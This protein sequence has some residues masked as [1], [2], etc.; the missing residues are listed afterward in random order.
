M[1]LSFPTTLARWLTR[2]RL[3]AQGWVLLACLWLGAIVDFSTPAV[4]DRAGNVKFQDFVQFYVGGTL[5]GSG[6]IALLY[7]WHTALERM[8]QIAPQWR[9]GLP[10]VYG[11]QVV[12]L[13]IP[14]SRLSFLTAAGIWVA[15]SAGV[16][17][18]CC[19]ALCRACP[20]LSGQSSLFWL[21]A[22]AYP[23]CFHF[24]IRGQISALILCCFT[25]A[26]F[27]FRE[28]RSFLAGLALGTLAF[29]PQFLIALPV[30]FLLARAWKP[31][32]GVIAGVIGQLGLTW[33]WCGSSVMRQYAQTLANL[34]RLVAAT[35]TTEAHAQMHSLRSFFSL[36]LPWPQ[37]AIGLSII[38]SAAVIVLAVRVWRSDA[39]L[40]VRFSALEVAAVLVNPHL[41][42]YD[43]LALAPMLILL[44]DWVLAEAAR[45]EAAPRD[46]LICGL[47]GTYLLPLFGPLTMITHLQL[48]VVALV[49]LQ[50]ELWRGWSTQSQ[51]PSHI[52]QAQAR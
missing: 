39:P 11:P 3:L 15:I 34:P 14:F 51:R 28:G 27:A 32:A 38:S 50:W 1:A 43:L 44:A 21:L 2:R 25:L 16:Y 52:E 5:A 26:Y 36:L 7:D 9:F 49:W 31:L 8:H 22:L 17:L 41:F 6:Q 45:A 20:A 46:A 48:S 29:K 12:A 23:A 19:Y 40:A 13:F 4:M 18:A 30:V 35:E 37:A 47:Y 33:M 24:V 10:M 42:V